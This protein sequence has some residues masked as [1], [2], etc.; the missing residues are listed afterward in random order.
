MRDEQCYLEMKL[1]KSSK[2]N[3]LKIW[4]NMIT[5][6]LGIILKEITVGDKTGN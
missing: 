6:D 3:V 5:I 2:G 4:F 1:S